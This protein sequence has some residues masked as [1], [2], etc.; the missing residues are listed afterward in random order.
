M[1]SE[2]FEYLRRIHELLEQIYTITDNQTTILLSPMN[3][4]EEEEN[5]ALDMIA[6]MADYKDEAT[7]ELIEAEN[8]FQKEYDANKHLVQE[9]EDISELKELVTEILKRKE[10]IIEH[11]Q[12]NLLILQA[13][14]KKKLERVHLP[15]NPIEASNA[16]KKQ[17]K[18]T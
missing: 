11:E 14:S 15:Q 12:S 5:N 8:M 16:Y 17:Q 9:A 18:R 6:Q 3:D 1:M 13:R 10:A 4:S 7:K 2:L